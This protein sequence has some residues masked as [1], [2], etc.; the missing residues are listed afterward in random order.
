MRRRDF[1][2]PVSAMAAAW[3]LAARAQLTN[4]VPKIGFIYPGPE[5]YAKMRSTLVLE[6]LRSQAF[7]N[8]TKLLSWSAPPA[9]IRRS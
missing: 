5:A 6:G 3:P 1:I 4:G 8:R 9:A 7:V 2:R